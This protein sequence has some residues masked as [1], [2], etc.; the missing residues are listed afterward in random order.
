[1]CMYSTNQFFL[2]KMADW[3]FKDAFVAIQSLPSILASILQGAGGL[4][5]G[6]ICFA[7]IQTTLQMCIMCITVLEKWSEGGSFNPEHIEE[8]DYSHSTAILILLNS[9]VEGTALESM[10]NGLIVHQ[11]KGPISTILKLIKYAHSLMDVE[12]QSPEPMH[13]MICTIVGN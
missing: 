1:M 3:T 8:G 12:G 4:C 9:T 10:S 13:R 2:F 5:L 6:H 7:K 11:C